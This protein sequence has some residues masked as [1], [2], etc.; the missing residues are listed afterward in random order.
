LEDAAEIYANKIAEM[1]KETF[2]PISCTDLE[3]IATNNKYGRKF[4][5]YFGSADSLNKKM[6][7]LHEVSIFDRFNFNLDSPVTF[8][9]NSEKACKDKFGF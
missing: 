4:F 2:M 3:E 9:Y 5:V 7:H 1:T 8:Y 6:K